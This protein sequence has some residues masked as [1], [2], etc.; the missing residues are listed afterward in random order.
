MGDAE[1][2][3]SRAVDFLPNQSRN[4]RQKIEVYNE[5][6]NRLKDS[7]DEEAK[8]PGFEDRLWAHFCRLPT[9]YSQP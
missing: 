5:V 4:H 1:S 9:R 8:L 3:S 6:L 7:N 2:C